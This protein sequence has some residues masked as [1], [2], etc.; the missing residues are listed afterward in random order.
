MKPALKKV[1]PSVVMSCLLAGAC[2]GAAGTAR[3]DAFAQAIL[4]ID[5][6]RVLHASGAAYASSDF[7]TFNGMNGAGASA[8]LNDVVNAAPEQNKPM[9]STPPDIAQRF[10][11]LP[12]APRAENDF[13]PFDTP[14]PVP[15]TFGYADQ[16][17]SGAMISHNGK[18]A[19]AKTQS[20][21]DA[22]LVED[23]SA[24]GSSNVGTLA[25]FKFMLGAADTMTFAFD[26]TPFTQAY[27]TGDPSKYAMARVTWTL[28]IRDDTGQSVFLFAPDELNAMTNV[29]RTDSFAGT[30]TYAPGTLNFSATTAMLKANTNYQLTISQT[31]VANAM[32][33]TEVPEP[34]SLALFGLGL[35]G[36]SMLRRRRR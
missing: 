9:F 27:S 13:S 18:A 17:M 30:T 5:H 34:G 2:L 36:V 8:T 31:S 26:A 19:G 23:G 16:Y 11:G 21:A 14:A 4:T 29:N 24:A 25:N 3:A 33:S 32:Q 20:R 1:R 12:A 10:V 35:L 15:G 28:N 22:A 6:F 7:K